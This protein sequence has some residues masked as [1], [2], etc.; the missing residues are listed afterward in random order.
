MKRQHIRKS[1]FTPKQV[2]EL[3]TKAYDINP[4][5]GCL[6]HI[7][8]LSGWGLQKLLEIKWRQVDLQRRILFGHKQLP[9]Y[10]EHIHIPDGLFSILQQLYKQ[11]SRDELLHKQ[12]SPDDEYLFS[13]WHRR[14]NTISSWNRKLIDSIG[15]D[16]Y[17]VIDDC[18]YR[19]YT[20]HSLRLTS[21]LNRRLVS[22]PTEVMEAMLFNAA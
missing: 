18:R 13:D 10:T 16:S 12:K 17:E 3:I 7:G 9:Y 14:T 22:N 2:K 5:F 1:I 19:H 21:L 6:W 11:K 4:S 8:Y 20:F 15:L